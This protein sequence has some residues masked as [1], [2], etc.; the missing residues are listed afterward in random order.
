MDSTGEI[1]KIQ[2]PEKTALILRK[3]DY[4]CVPRGEV[5][6]KGKGIMM[7]YWVLAKDEAASPTILPAGMPLARTPTPNSL[8]RQTSSHSSLAAVVLGMIQ[9]SQQAGPSTRK[10]INLI[11]SNHITHTLLVHKIW[12][13]KNNT[14]NL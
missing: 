9:V 6:V 5:N 13:K 10:F 12:F 7:T 8:Q 14:K 1:W 3:Y 2:V 11:L 4:N